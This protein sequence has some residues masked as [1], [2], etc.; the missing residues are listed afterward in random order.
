MK[1]VESDMVFKLLRRPGI[2][3]LAG[4]IKLRTFYYLSGVV[5]SVEVVQGLVVRVQVK[6]HVVV[7]ILKLNIFN[8]LGEKPIVDINTFR[9]P[10][11]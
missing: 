11:H 4:K 10:S 8:K 5:I 2:D 9:K 3:S 7:T 1:M 6:V